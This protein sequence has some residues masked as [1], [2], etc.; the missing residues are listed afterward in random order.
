ML[1]EYKD[2]VKMWIFITVNVHLPL[3]SKLVQHSI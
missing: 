2:L 1:K 3:A